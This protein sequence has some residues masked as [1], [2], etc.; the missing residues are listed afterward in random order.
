MH[1]LLA[2]NTLMRR[3]PPSGLSTLLGRSALHIGHSIAGSTKQCPDNTLSQTTATSLRQRR[4]LWGHLIDDTFQQPSN[5]S[6]VTKEQINNCQ[7][8]FIPL[9]I[10]KLLQTEVYIAQ[11]FWSWLLLSTLHTFPFSIIHQATQ[12][13]SWS[14]SNAKN[15]FCTDLDWQLKLWYFFSSCF[16]YFTLY[17]TILSLCLILSKLSQGHKGCRW[18]YCHHSSVGIR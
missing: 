1:W 4:A 6:H 5:C 15:Y 13:F 17:T 11:A 14:H 7:C 3:R 18:V 12:H 2:F 10:L 9:D 8:H 16:S